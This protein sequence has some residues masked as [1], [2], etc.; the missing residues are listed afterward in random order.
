MSVFILSLVL[1]PGVG[2]LGSGVLGLRGLG[3]KIFTKMVKFMLWRWKKWGG[4]IKV[5]FCCVMGFDEIRSRLYV[6]GVGAFGVAWGCLLWI[7]WFL[8]V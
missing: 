7:G 3:V 8:R 5:G 4:L 6:E 2:F 1:C